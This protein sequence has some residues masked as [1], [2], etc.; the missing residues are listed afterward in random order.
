[1]G[2]FQNFGH[3]SP[4]FTLLANF[5]VQL[6]YLVILAR[7]SDLLDSNLP[8]IPRDSNL[9]LLD[10]LLVQDLKLVD[11]PQLPLPPVALQEVSLM[12]QATSSAPLKATFLI[13][14]MVFFVVD[15]GQSSRIQASQTST[16]KEGRFLPCP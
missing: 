8:D 11:L 14:V 5:R 2:H 12:T 1:M 7:D 6:D 9:H 16:S 13:M 15:S 10:Y 4:Q 3:F